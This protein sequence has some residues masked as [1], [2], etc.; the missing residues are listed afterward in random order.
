MSHLA[1]I[2][3]VHLKA[4]KYEIQK[5]STCR[6]TLFRCKF[7]SMFPVFHLVW[8]TCRA[9]NTFVAGWRNLLRKVEPGSTSSNKFWFCCSYSSNSQLV[10]QQICS[11]PSKSTNQRAAFLQPATNVFVGGQ[12]NHARWKTGNIDENLQRNNVA[13]QVKGF[14]YLVFRRLYLKPV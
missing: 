6:T 7:S 10:A 12:V 14:L 4:A 9:T 1:R 13:R 8:S 2:Q 11:C 3:T 5:P